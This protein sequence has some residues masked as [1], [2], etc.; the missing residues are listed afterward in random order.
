MNVNLA[1]ESPITYATSSPLKRVLTGTTTAPASWA[2]KNA[3][4]HSMLLGRRMATRSPRP[5]PCARRPPATRA[6][7]SHSSP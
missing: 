5:T 6:A 3:S 4:T 2:P 7:R 1:P